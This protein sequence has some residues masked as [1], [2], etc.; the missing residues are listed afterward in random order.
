MYHA[1]IIGFVLSAAVIVYVLL[2]YPVLLGWLARRAPGK[3]IYKE[4]RER[5]VTVVLPVHNGA[6]WLRDK[7]ESILA[8]DY[9]QRL[10]DIIVISDGSTDG[11]DDIARSFLSRMRM[12]ILYLPKCGKARCLNVALD[13]AAGEILFYTDVRQ[14][15]DRACLRNLISCFADPTVGVVSGELII[16]QGASAAEANIDRYWRYEKWIRKS[17]SAIDSVPGATGA[18]YAMRRKLARPMP[19]DTL[20][21]DVYLPMGAFFAGYRI[22]LDDSAIAYDYPTSLKSEFRRKVRTLAGVYQLMG[23]YPALLGPANRMWIHF[24]SH[25]LGR[26]LLPFAFLGLLVCSFGLPAPLGHAA[27]FLQ[28]AFYAVAALDPLAPERWPLKRITSP[29]RT[30]VVL[31]LASLCAVSIWFIPVEYF[32]K[33]TRSET[34]REP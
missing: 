20:L 7:L 10:V 29:I 30:F 4:F 34:L 6:L 1:A 26:L 12:E 24:V 18:V 19:A 16:L 22:L 5:T 11:T 31:M 2:G 28:A 32:W 25:K 23:T 27:L 9:P 3:R 8:Q 14:R 13:R 33:P 17:L 21:D 15:L